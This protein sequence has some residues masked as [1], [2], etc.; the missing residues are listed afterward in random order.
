MTVLSIQSAVSYGHVGNAAA[1]FA[2]RRL[3]ID[4]WPVDT[5]RFSNHPGHGDWRGTVAEASEVAAIV[6]G[7]AARGAFEDCE[8]VLSGY[9][10]K[11]ATGTVAGDAVSAV[12]AANP[13]SVYCCD[14]VMGD[15]A[16][17]L[18]VAPNVVTAIATDL[19]PKA[20]IAVPNA[21]ELAHLTGQPVTD[22]A[23]SLTAAD[24][25]MA[26]GPRVVVATSVEAGETTTTLAVTADG[27][28]RVTTPYLNTPAKGA[29][30]LFAALFLGRY[31]MARSVPEALALAVASVFAVMRATAD[32]GAPEM[33]LVAA[34]D[35]I[36][37]P[38]ERFPVEEA[39]R[40]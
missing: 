37:D 40:P 17:G 16:E 18:Y 34:Q 28:W 36:V 19:I 26:R 15:G 24:S 30:D 1:V 6:D 32:A 13:E 29:G 25:L 4:V 14:P 10:G 5:V 20:D 11:A 2:L 21:F 8:A 31:L 33:C 39:R 35:A 3:G 38:P 12:K 27:A 23:G 9:L 7:L 22:V